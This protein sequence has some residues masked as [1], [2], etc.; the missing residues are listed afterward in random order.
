MTNKVGRPKKIENMTD[1]ERIEHWRRERIAAEKQRQELIDA[2]SDGQR[3]ALKEMSRAAE[4]IM[5]SYREMWHPNWQDI[6]RLDEA[7]STFNSQFNRTLK[8][9]ES[10]DRTELKT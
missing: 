2:L 10:R 6:V 7:L 3:E 1:D 5:T 4:D 8:F 9:F